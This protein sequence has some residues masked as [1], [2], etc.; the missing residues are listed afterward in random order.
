MGQLPRPFIPPV[1]GYHVTCADPW[2]VVQAGGLW[3]TTHGCP[4]YPYLRQPGRV[5]GVP[6]VYIHTLWSRAEA[7]G[8]S[9]SITE[10][11]RPRIYEVRLD[12]LEVRPDPFAS[13]NCSLDGACYVVAPLVPLHR[14]SLVE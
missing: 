6:R 12:G 14:L 13:R 5:V 1:V 9:R 2:L 4:N 8:L 3:G 11:R 10:L 7:W